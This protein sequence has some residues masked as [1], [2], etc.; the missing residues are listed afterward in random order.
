MPNNYSPGQPVDRNG[1]AKLNYPPARIA[2]ATTHRENTGTSSVLLFTHNTTE[3]EVGTV[4]LGVAGRWAGN[5]ATSV[6]V[7]N[8][9]TPNFDFVVS[10]AT[11]RRFVVPQS[12]VGNYGSVQGVNRAEGLYQ[13]VAFISLTGGNGSVLTAEF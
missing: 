11:V 7:S 6:V 12:V 3:I 13:G 8:A 5:S 2:L 4:G 1:T 9:G 10:A